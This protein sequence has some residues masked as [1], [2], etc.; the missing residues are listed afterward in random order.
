MAFHLC[1]NKSSNEDF[2]ILK[3]QADHIPTVISRDTQ[4][5][6]FQTR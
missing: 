6:I 1:K 3:A 4:Y 2:S 5:F